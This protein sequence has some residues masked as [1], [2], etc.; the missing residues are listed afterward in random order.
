MANFSSIQITDIGKELIARA[1]VNKEVITFT[2]IATS[3]NVK[4]VDELSGLTS[5]PEIMQEQVFSSVSYVSPNCVQFEASF[6]NTGLSE[7]YNVR[8]FGIFGKTAKLSERL[9]AVATVMDQAQSDWMSPQ[10]GNAVITMRLKASIII[11]SV[12]VTAITINPD[13]YVTNETFEKRVE[14]V[15]KELQ[16]IKDTKQ[17]KIKTSLGIRIASDGVT[18]NSANYFTFNTGTL[19]TFISEGANR[20]N[21]FINL[22]NYNKLISYIDEY[23]DYKIPIIIDYSNQ[24]LNPKYERDADDNTL[25][26]IKF[27]INAVGSSG[28]DFAPYGVQ[29]VFDTV[30]GKVESVAINNI[31]E[32]KLAGQLGTLMRADVQGLLD[33]VYAFENTVDGAVASSES[34]EVIRDWR[35]DKYINSMKIYDGRSSRYFIDASLPKLYITPQMVMPE[36]EGLTLNN[37]VT[38]T[39]RANL[40][41][42]FTQAFIFKK[43]D[44]HGA[45]NFAYGAKYDNNKNRIVLRGTKLFVTLDLSSTLLN[46][47]KDY[48]N[49]KETT[50]G[51]FYPDHEFYNNSK[52][53][54]DGL[55]LTNRSSVMGVSLQSFEENLPRYVNDNSSGNYWNSSYTLFVYLRVAASNLVYIGLQPAISLMPEI[56]LPYMTRESNGQY[57]AWYFIH[58]KNDYYRITQGSTMMDAVFTTQSDNSS[59]T[60]PFAFCMYAGYSNATC[61]FKNE[62]KK[63]ILWPL[64]RTL[65]TPYPMWCGD[66]L[67]M[68]ED[69]DNIITLD[70]NTFSALPTEINDSSTYM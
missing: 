32:N 36:W 34:I 68:V 3:K 66:A 61:C 60:K 63:Q 40:K 24:I 10:T 65:S 53:H 23:N 46:L 31:L 55:Y 5:L 18:L 62:A 16:Q 58:N 22:T 26:N 52:N 11:S 42:R 14:Y 6:T 56:V 67:D 47:M 54:L 13:E 21:D 45:D 7:G 29:I 28:L 43:I 27:V 59:Y 20:P 19:D 70:W 30:V 37:G 9:I 25:M 17:D 51:Y 35:S 15:D 64:G 4:T 41:N 57:Y 50:T 69:Q 39:N 38:L 8:M 48:K 44:G 2:K 49:A 12:E 1:Q 33:G